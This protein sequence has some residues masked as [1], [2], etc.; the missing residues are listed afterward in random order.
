MRYLTPLAM[1]ILALVLFT[2]GTSRAVQVPSGSYQQ[3]CRDIGVRG[4]TLYAECQDGSGGWHRTELR[5]FRRCGGD[6]QNA[7]GNLQCAAGSNRGYGRDRDNDQ[8]R[9][10]RADRDHDGDRDRDGDRDHDRRYGYNGGPRGSYQQSCQN[11]SVN[12]AVLQA[13]CQK[14][15]GKWKN[16][17]LRYFERCQDIVNNNGKLECR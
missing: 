4:S 17:S 16:S 1:F 2:S 9:D 7:S 3:S 11:I 6:V 14:K 12:G 8:D 15:N 5:D 10:R 13:S